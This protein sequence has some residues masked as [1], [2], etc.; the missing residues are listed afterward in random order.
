MCLDVYKLRT[1]PLPGS[2]R[3]LSLVS[4]AALMDRTMESDTSGWNRLCLPRAVN[5]ASPLRQG[6]T[7]PESQKSLLVGTVCRHVLPQEASCFGCGLSSA[8]D[9]EGEECESL[10]F[11]LWRPSILPVTVTC[12]SLPLFQFCLLWSGTHHV[13]VVRIVEYLGLYLLW[14][15]DPDRSE[16]PFNLDN[17]LCK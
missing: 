4:V 6:S 3:Q 16:H 17:M 11:G 12:Y 1:L 15:S 10:F 7:L 2:A 9:G 13:C 8:S 14:I 5:T